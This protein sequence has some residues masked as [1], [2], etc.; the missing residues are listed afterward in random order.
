MLK[1]LAAART[2]LGIY[3][4]NTDHAP[5]HIHTINTILSPRNKFQFFITRDWDNKWREIYR[6]AIQEQ[7]VLY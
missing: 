6:K 4:S 5:R 1:A 7:L 2:R 3:Y